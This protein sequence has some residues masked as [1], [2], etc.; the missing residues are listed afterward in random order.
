MFKYYLIHNKEKYR[1]KHMFKLFEKYGVDL[2]QLKIIDYPNKDELTYKLK[3][4]IVQK[5]SYMRDGWIS[6][7]YKHYLAINDI[8]QNNYPYG[9]VMEDN[10]GD[11]YENVPLRLE[12]YLNELPENWGIVYDSVWGKLTE[13]DEN[14]DQ[15][16]KLVYKKSIEHI[17]FP[18]GRV[19][20]HGG[21]RAAQFYFLNLKTA[22]KMVENFIPFNHSAD[23]WM[24]TVLRR[25]DIHTFWSEPSLVVSKLN[26]KSS[27]L[28]YNEKYFYRIK[29][30]VIN[31]IL[32]I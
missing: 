32:D 16:S 2:N 10:I 12:K 28:F 23:M 11:F 20:S 18:D 3:K 1:K 4:Q 15:F 14:P 22:K 31:K 21:T 17:E 5:K 19:I 25:G 8:V 13:Y 27:T 7:S 26:K 29:S 30:K 9:V 24:N 6:C